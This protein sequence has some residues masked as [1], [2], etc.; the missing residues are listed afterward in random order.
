MTF[1][2]FETREE[3]V[4]HGREVFRNFDEDWGVPVYS[5]TV[6]EAE[7]DPYLFDAMSSGFAWT[8]G[9]DERCVWRAAPSNIF[10]RMEAD[11]QALW[12]EMKEE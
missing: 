11:E 3:A 2:A 12:E 7:M 6:H 1:G 5:C 10:N 4:N 9:L 8:G